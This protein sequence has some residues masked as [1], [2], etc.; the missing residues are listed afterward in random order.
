MLAFS[1]T[2]VVQGSHTTRYKGCPVRKI[3]H[4]KSRSANL[5]QSDNPCNSGHK[6]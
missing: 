1:N 2:L 5:A 4:L 3:F 6:R